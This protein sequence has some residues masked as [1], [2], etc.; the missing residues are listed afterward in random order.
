MYANH[1]GVRKGNCAVLLT[2]VKAGGFGTYTEPTFL[3]A[4]NLSARV[5]R[6]GREWFVWKSEKIGV[7][8]ERLE[9]IDR[10]SR[11]LKDALLPTA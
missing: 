11:D 1:V 2:P 8:Q 9:E 6:Q 5:I 10:F 7:T 3:V 4:G